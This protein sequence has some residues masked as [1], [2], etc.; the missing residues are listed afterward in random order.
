MSL[1]RRLHGTNRNPVLLVCSNHHHQNGRRGHGLVTT[2]TT[3]AVCCLKPTSSSCQSSI[4]PLLYVA[5]GT[6]AGTLTMAESLEETLPLHIS[7]I[8]PPLPSLVA[9]AVAYPQR[10]GTYRSHDD[11]DDEDDDHSNNNKSRQAGSCNHRLGPS[12]C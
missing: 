7:A 9:A 1:R 10:N 11:E 2:T 8:S 12:S 4:V 3:L 6:Q 5:V